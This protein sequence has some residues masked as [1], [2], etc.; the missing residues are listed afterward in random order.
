MKKTERIYPAAGR[1]VHSA[2]ALAITG[3]IGS[4]AF[5]QGEGFSTLPTVTVTGTREAEKISETPVSVGVV[6]RESIQFTRPGHP[7]E[8]LGQVPGV[9]VGITNGEGH[10]TAIRQGFTTAPVYL[11]LEDGI[12]TRATGNLNHNAMFE[13][14]VPSA[15]GVEVIRG[16]GTALYGSDAIG[17]IVNVLT[18]QPSAKSGADASLEFGQHGYQRLLGGFDTG[19]SEKDAFRADLNLTHTDGW[20]NS[21]RLHMNSISCSR[22]RPVRRWCQGDS[23]WP[24]LPFGAIAMRR[25]V[26]RG[27]SC[28][29]SM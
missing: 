9:A 5:A 8:I 12:P 27:T 19:R 21:S 25:R 15:G 4:N 14:N 24:V 20:R 29:W 13:L 3:L 28:R 11:Y 10:T 17:G 16:I 7:S 18:R 26:R 6:P 1:Q 23:S 22:S 2:I